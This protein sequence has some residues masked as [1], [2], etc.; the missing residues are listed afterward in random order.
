MKTIAL[1]LSFIFAF[2]GPLM[3][4]NVSGEKKFE[5]HG[6]VWTAGLFKSWLTDEYVGF[7]RIGNTV[8][9]VFTEIKKTGFALQ[10]HYMYKPNSWMGLGVH[11]GLG[12]DVH[13]YIEAPVL[14]F[15]VSVSFG[16]N[17]QFVIDIGWVDTKRKIITGDVRSDLMNGNYTE[18]PEVYELTE[19]NTGFSIGLGYRIF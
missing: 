13:S 12:L 9:P 2:G 5:K 19:L 3:G 7:N 18:I 6:V 4:Q 10:S 16:N 8:T 15:G 11:L 17:H 1:L 14:L